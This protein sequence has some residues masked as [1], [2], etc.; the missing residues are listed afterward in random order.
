MVL[1]M[2]TKF[3][4]RKAYTKCIEIIIAMYKILNCHLFRHFPGARNCLLVYPYFLYKKFIEDQTGIIFNKIHSHLQNG[5]ILDV[6]ACLGYTAKCFAN[7]DFSDRTVFAFEPHPF[8]YQQLKKISR[9]VSNITPINVAIGPRNGEI[10]LF[11]NQDSFADHRVINS[12]FES[13]IG[14]SDNRIQVPMIS[15]D[16]F[17][18]E[19]GNIDVAL[20]KIDVQGYEVEVCRGMIETI[21]NNPDIMVL[22]ELAPTALTDLGFKFE[23]IFSFFSQRGFDCYSLQDSNIIKIDIKRLTN[24]L[25]YFEY[26]DVIFTKQILTTR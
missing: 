17:I 21:I 13:K 6:G 12:V 23:E 14:Q 16:S 18:K 24:I 9:S 26:I 4:N 7:K 22:I 2:L 10:S 5:C 15:I 20:V 1:P 3:I 11:E 25:K 19:S 8:N